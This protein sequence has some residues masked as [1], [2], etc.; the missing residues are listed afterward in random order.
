MAKKI[1]D[2]ST[3]KDVELEKELVGLKKEIFNLKINASTIHVK[4]YSQFKKLRK[5]VAQALTESNR[6]RLQG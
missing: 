3:F 1:V 6:R 5:K 4:D 2:Y